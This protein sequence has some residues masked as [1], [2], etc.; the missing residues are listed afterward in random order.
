MIKP[1]NFAIHVTYTCPLTCAHCCFL[2]SP[3]RKEALP[4]DHIIDTIQSI[5]T[6][7]IQL[8]SFTG[9]EPFLLGNKLCDI[10]RAAS[11]HGLTTRV[12]T[13]AYFGKH[14]F[15]AERRL[16]ELKKNGLNELT[17]SWDDYHEK[18]VSFEHV[19]NVFWLAKKL[20]LKMAINIV[21]G[22][23]TNWTKNKLIKALGIT[24][25]DEELIMEADLNLTG[26]AETDLVHDVL[27]QESL[28][29]VGPCPYVLSGPTLNANNKL[30]A[31]CGVIPETN[32]LVLDHEFTP[33]NLSS[34]LQKG[35]NNPLLNWIHLYGPHNILQYISE[36]NGVEIPQN[37]NG[38]CEACRIL[39]HT[40]A[41]SMHIQSAIKENGS[42][43]LDEVAI[44][45]EL[46][47]I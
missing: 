31:C 2:S 5:D 8:I 43:I 41:I 32:L 3:D 20:E 10:V 24:N 30:L 11:E 36:R 26:R 29:D 40:P 23:N 28:G 7:M 14:Y 19:Y 42:N 37:I 9:G 18:F 34:A 46:N 25:S 47:W 38:N 33:T 16:T 13:S 6:S 21:K 44:L 1:D 12:I 4:I 39:F 22:K 35:S 45:S 27:Y 15:I 17:I